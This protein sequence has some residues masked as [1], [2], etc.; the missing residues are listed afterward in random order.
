[1]ASPTDIR[2]GK[3]ILYQNIPH[4]VLDMQHRT[5]GRRAGFIQTTLR[6]L[7]TLSST[8]V[9]FNSN[10]SVTFCR[11]ETQNFEYSYVD[12]TGYHF[13][14]PETFEDLVI[15][16]PLADPQKDFLAVGNLYTLMFVDEKPA[17]VQLP[18]SVEMSVVEA[19]EGLRGDSATNAQKT[20]TTESGMSL[21]VPLFIKRGDRIRISTDDGSY[22]GRA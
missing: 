8:S 10:D 5:P 14:N 3:V 16:R 7:Q 12:S 6:N 11:M 22:I 19:P 18:S 1:M 20:A 2:K 15:A 4:L 9:R 17:Q 21:Q 13:L